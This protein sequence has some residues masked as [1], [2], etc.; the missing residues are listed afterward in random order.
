MFLS[1]QWLFKGTQQRG[2]S[3]CKSKGVKI[4]AGG[5]LFTSEYERFETVDHFVLNEAEITLPPF[6]KDLDR[7]DAKRFYTTSEFP[8][9]RTTPVPQ[10]ELVDLKRYS[11][12]S[13]QYSRGCPYNCEFCN[14]TA[15]LGHRPR[16]KTA[17]Q[18]IAELDALYERGWR[19]GVFFVDDNFIGNKKSLRTEILPALIKW[20]ADKK[21]ITFNTEVRSIW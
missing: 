16:I 4:V 7:D 5:P 9:L 6:L 20:Q 1:V 8:D 3:R 19:G 12:M 11:S 10:W 21:G 17:A 13:I 2:L 18:I 15:M 14:V